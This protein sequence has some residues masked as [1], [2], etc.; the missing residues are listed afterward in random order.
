MTTLDN[1]IQAALASASDLPDDITEPNL[2]SDLM[3]T[4]QGRHSWLMKWGIV[5]MVVAVIVM[6]ICMP[7]SFSCRKRRWP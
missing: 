3:D 5:K 7:I 4:L 1:K 6:G 2:T